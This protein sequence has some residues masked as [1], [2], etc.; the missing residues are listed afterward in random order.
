MIWRR[1]PGE[2]YFTVTAADEDRFTSDR[3]R[4][5]PGR[6][7][8]AR[9]SPQC[10]P[11][12]QPSPA[13]SAR[14]RRG[15]GRYGSITTAQARP[16]GRVAFFL[17]FSGSDEFG[18]RPADARSVSGSWGVHQG[19]DGDGS[20]G[21]VGRRSHSSSAN[22]P[23]PALLVTAA[24]VGQRR[25]RPR[26][27]ARHRQPVRIRL[28][29]RNMSIFLFLI[30]CSPPASTGCPRRSVHL[31]AR[32]GPCGT[33]RV[34]DPESRAGARDGRFRKDHAT[35]RR[36]PGTAWSPYGGRGCPASERTTARER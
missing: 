8:P 9:A 31:G 35:A 2:K 10:T 7:W 30:L 34:S 4:S 13:A 12:N 22:A 20:L 1:P 36:V 18:P 23:V 11:A 26:A 24:G 21:V 15:S 29:E 6:R 25:G 16:P 33:P 28:Y 14:A 32:P 17:S 27:V 3:A 19:R 5:Q